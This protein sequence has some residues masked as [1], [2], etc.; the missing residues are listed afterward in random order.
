M[1][2]TSRRP[3]SHPVARRVGC[4][5]ASLEHV[6]PCRGM[7]I[8]AIQAVAET[9][10]SRTANC[11]E[12]L[13][14]T[15]R[16]TLRLSVRPLGKAPIDGLESEPVIAIGRLKVT[17]KQRGA[18]LVFQADDFASEA[19]AEAFLPKLKGGLL[20]LALEYNIAFTPYF[21]RR[22]ITRTEDPYAAA[23]NIAKSFGMPLEEQVKPVHGLTEEEG[24]T[25]FRTD[26]TIKFLGFAGGSASASIGL[27]SAS[28]ALS[29]GIEQVRLSPDDAHGALDIALDLYLSSF[30]EVSIRARFLTLMMA[31]EV[32][33]PVTEKHLAAVQMLTNLQTAIDGQL[34][35]ETDPDARDALESLRRDTKFR[36]ET[37]IRRRI[38]R[39]VLDNVPLNEADRESLAKKVVAAYDLRGSVIHTGTVDTNA[40]AV[41]NETAL[42]VIKLL[43]KG[44]LGLAVVPV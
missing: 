42:Y 11:K 39:L 19:E 6:R 1:D 13:M 41:A 18:F 35:T 26:E 29:H 9:K 38:R 22:D 31:L 21:E 33:A 44:L 5:G 14:T 30:Y 24:Y 25:I 43:L 7:R 15:S 10:T 8:S 34:A 3:F 32:L 23:R 36:K 37:S 4:R 40:L 20:S 17:L 12:I 27:D 2:A 28:R 16:Y